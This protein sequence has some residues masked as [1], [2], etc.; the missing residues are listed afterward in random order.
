M[1][2]KP[3]SPLYTPELTS[4]RVLS[5]SRENPST[6]KGVLTKKTSIE[7]GKLTILQTAEFTSGYILTYDPE[8]SSASITHFHVLRRLDA[9]EKV[10]VQF[11]PLTGKK[12]QLRL[13]S[14]F[15]LG[16]PVVG[17]HRYGY[18]QDDEMLV[19]TRMADG[20]YKD[21][22][23]LHCYRI[24]SKEG[25]Q[26]DLTAGFTTGRWGNVWNCVRLEVE[27]GGFEEKVRE[28]SKSAGDVFLDEE[29]QQMLD[30]PKAW[31]MGIRG[32]LVKQEIL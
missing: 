8:I 31:A 5:L 29:V 10:L 17:D 25:I 18:P 30:N 19:S 11:T 28:I 15:L 1:K 26:F 2:P 27:S 24:A 32:P 12:H 21:G 13:H 7:V 16:A 6:T 4:C 22:Y 23:A 9:E 3:G 14:A 20:V